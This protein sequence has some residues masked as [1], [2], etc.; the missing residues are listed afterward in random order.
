[1]PRKRKRDQDGIFARQDSPFW[2]ASF[3]DGRGKP[4]RRSTGVRREEDPSGLKAK[5]IRAQW[6]LEVEQ[7][8]QQGPRPK[9]QGHTFDELM[10]AYLG[11]VTPTKRSPDRDKWSAKQ[12]FP[13]FTGR[14]LETLGVADARS[15]T[16]KRT[17]DGVGPAT[18]NKEVGLFSAALNWARR[19]L[20]WE[21]PN[22]FQG[23]RRREP[24]GR[25]RWLSTSEATA[26]KNAAQ[27]ADRAPHLLDFIRLG[28]NTGMRPGE[29]LSLQWRRVDLGANL[30]YL[31][32]ED[33]KS[34]K[35]GSVPLNQ[36]AC[37]T[38]LSRARFRAEFCPASPTADAQTYFPR[39][40]CGESLD[41]QVAAL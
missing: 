5:S 28:L 20:E 33:Q 15:Y 10:L 31:G 4:A 25:N 29:M 14:L 26:L 38:M 1:M 2:W 36:E 13:I 24:A 41:N 17:E 37:K 9:V 8:R 3:T 6:I 19:E 7:E 40:L 39:P 21:V 12:L 30:V 11:Q 32:A 23:R 35:V 18:I 34:G 22:P 27:E 16:A